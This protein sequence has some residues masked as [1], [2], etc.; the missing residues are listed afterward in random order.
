MKT[1]SPCH[2]FDEISGI[3]SAQPLSEWPVKADA[4]EVYTV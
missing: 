3:I 1:Q 4:A 2:D